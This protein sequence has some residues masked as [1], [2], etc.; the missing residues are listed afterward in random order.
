MRPFAFVV[1]SVPLPESKWHH[2]LAGANVHIW[3]MDNSIDSARNR[4]ICYIQDQAWKPHEIRFETE[5]P[6]EQIPSLGKGEARLYNQALTSG[7][8]ADFL[9]FPLQDGDPDDPVVIGQL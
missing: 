6:R 8:A 1:A 9:A 7:L 2:Q 4:A 5:I 3:V